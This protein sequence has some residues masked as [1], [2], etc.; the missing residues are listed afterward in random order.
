MKNLNELTSQESGI[1][2]YGEGG[3]IVTN[4]AELG[5]DALPAL[6]PT[7]NFILGWPHDD[8][9]VE[10]SHEVEDVREELPG[11]VWVKDIDEGTLDTDMDIIYD[12]FGDLPALWGFDTGCGAE[13][14]GGPTPGVVYV[15]SD[16]TKV[17]APD[18]WN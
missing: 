4:W 2:V 15:L 11:T 16:G 3:V 9:D 17:I 14:V 1:V 10:S 18:G 6:D 13:V 7:G 5:D 12:K 8:L